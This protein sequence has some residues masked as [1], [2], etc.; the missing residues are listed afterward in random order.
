[1]PLFLL[2]LLF[3]Y[4]N[5][6]LKPKHVSNGCINYDDVQYVTDEDYEEINKRSKVDIHDILMGMIG[7]IG[8]LALIREEPDFAI[9][10]VAL[11]K[12]TGDVDYQFLYQALQTGYVTNQLSAG[13]DGGTQK[14]MSLKKI[15]ELDIPYPEVQEQEQIGIYFKNLDHLITL[16]QRKCEETKTLKK[17]ML[18]KMFPQ[19]GTNVPEIRFDG[20]TDAWEQRK[21]KD[22]APLQ[23]GFDL[24]TSQMEE[25]VYPVVMSNGI[26]GYHSQYKV[27]G[28]GIVTGRSGTIGKLHYIEGDYWPH[29]TTLWV[30]NF[31]GNN[32]KF[33]YYMYQCLDLSRFST[34]S[35]VPT[36]NRNDVH[37]EVV[38]IP[39]LSEQ[40]RISGYLTYLDHL[41]TLHQRK[42]DE[43]VKIKKYMLQNMFV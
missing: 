43:L 35:G 10:N 24:P 37:D 20:F 2:S 41:I 15:R 1:M 40:K 39:S 34:G 38:C 23:R 6:I 17:Y 7:T 14:F 13:M 25:G 29:N 33:I 16:R 27:E 19:N 3:T 28:P 31:Y 12:Y 26:G 9:K 30:T 22:I 11:I 21:V 5:L 36:L 32:Q 8:N 18:Q 4:F 42:C